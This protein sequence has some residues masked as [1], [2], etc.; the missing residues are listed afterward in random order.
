M[1]IIMIEDR[2]ILSNM[3]DVMQNDTDDVSTKPRTKKK[4]PGKKMTPDE[5]AVALSYE[6]ATG[7][8]EEI[9]KSLEGGT[10]S[11][12]ESLSLYEE[13]VALVRRCSTELSKAEQKVKVL[14]R[15]AE[16]NIQ[17]VDFKESAGD[18]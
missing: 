15:N 1:V 17:P 3:P 18:A 16:G 8:L 9:V 14:R 6:A 13:G 11:L 2:S 7:R 5:A 10:L 4:A 12:E